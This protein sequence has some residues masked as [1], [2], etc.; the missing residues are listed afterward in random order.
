MTY[1]HLI[2]G[3]LV[4]I[5]LCGF[6]V[7]LAFPPQQKVDVGSSAPA[8]PAG[9]V[10]G[11]GKNQSPSGQAFYT[12]PQTAKIIYTDSGFS[13]A[14]LSIPAGTTVVFQNQ[15]SVS[16]WPA[17]DPYPAN[18]NYPEEGICS[19][20]AFDACGPLITG[21]TWQFKFNRTGS[22]GYHD[23]L[24]LGRNGIIIVR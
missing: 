17:S 1:G 13:P 19:G 24:N 2:A 6:V 11:P 16:F 23:N 5:A 12:A 20:R 8:A 4:L 3:I 15:S 18:T 22:W 9:T 7:F 21:Q 14:Y 10:Y